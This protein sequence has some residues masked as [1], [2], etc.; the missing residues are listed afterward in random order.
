MPPKP[1]RV[2]GEAD[3]AT[4]NDSSPSS[5]VSPWLRPPAVAT[6]NSCGPGL[7]ASKVTEP[8]VA[9]AKSAALV[10]RVAGRPPCARFQLMVKVSCAVSA[11]PLWVTVKRGVWPS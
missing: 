6:V 7:S 2:V 10:L 4:V 5:S 8:L 9:E 3:N 1:A 11:G